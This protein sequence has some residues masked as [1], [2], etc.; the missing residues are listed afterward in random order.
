MLS[1]AQD[2]KLKEVLLEAALFFSA[3]F[4][5]NSF[6]QIVFRSADPNLKLT[7]LGLILFPGFAL[8]F[9]REDDSLRKRTLWLPAVVN[10]LSQI[11]GWMFFVYRL[12]NL[13]DFT[14]VLMRWFCYLYFLI[15]P[16]LL[17]IAIPLF[18]CGSEDVAHSQIKVCST[19]IYQW[20]SPGENGEE[21][22]IVIE[23]RIPIFSEFFFRTCLDTIDRRSVFVDFKVVDNE[24]IEYL[25]EGKTVRIKVN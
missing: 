16:L 2:R 20:K 14:R 22:S 3:N 24:F 19:I 6:G 7:I 23:K 15:E 12:F 9:L 10:L 8:I 5:V 1:D 13:C 18:F 21:D 11:L 4:V 25:K 17:I